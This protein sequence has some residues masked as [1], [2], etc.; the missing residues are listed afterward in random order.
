MFLVRL[1]FFSVYLL[2]P[3]SPPQYT[4]HIR[5]TWL[6]LSKLLYFSGFQFCHF[7]NWDD[8]NSSPIELLG[9]LN[10]IIQAKRVEQRAARRERSTHIRLKTGCAD[11]SDLGR[12]SATRPQSFLRVTSGC[13]PRAKGELGSCACPRPNETLSLCFC[14]GIRLKIK[15]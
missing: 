4:L 2:A 14:F 1:T 6:W 13:G 9:G 7:C 8:H 5:I 12:V 10:E 3:P 11:S 15:S